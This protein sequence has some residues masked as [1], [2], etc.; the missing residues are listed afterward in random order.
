MRTVTVT[1]GRNVGTEPM[2][3]EQW[4]HFVAKVRNEVSLATEEVWAVA[5]YQGSW[6]GVR[7]DAVV[8]YGPLKE[9]RLEILRS[10][11]S[12]LATYYSQDA[13]GLSVG[14][15]ELVKRWSREEVAA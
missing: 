9:P 8:F 14:E 3:R 1:I 6:E 13:I 15:G 5:P 12:N 7:E 2:P 4:N 11:L 10:S